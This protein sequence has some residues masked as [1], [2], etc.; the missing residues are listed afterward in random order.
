MASCGNFQTQITAIMDI[1]TES[2]ISEII[3]FLED[4][5]SALC[6][7]IS[8][9]LLGNEALKNKLHALQNG[10]GRARGHK[11][12][13]M[14][15]RSVNTRSLGVQ[16][17][18][19]EQHRE[20]VSGFKCCFNSGRNGEPAGAGDVD[21][22]LQADIIQNQSANK[23]NVR[24]EPL[25]IKQ[26]RLEE[27]LYYSDPQPSSPGE[28][29]IVPISADGKKPGTE[30][31]LFGDPEELREQHSCGHGDEELS[32]LEFVVKVEQEGE[33]VA[34]GLNLTGCGRSV[35]RLSNLGSE[36]V[37]YKRDDKLWTSFTQENSDIESDDPACCSA[38]EQ[39]SQSL[40][41]LSPIHQTPATMEDSGNTLSFV[42]A[43]CVE[44]FDKMGEKP[45]ACSEELRSE[46]IH[47]QQGQY[48]ERLEHTV[49]RENQ[50]LLPQQQQHGPSV[51]HRRGSESPAQPHS[52]SPYETGCTLRTGA[53][54][55]GKMDRK[56]VSVYRVKLTLTGVPFRF[57][58]ISTLDL[59]NLSLQQMTQLGSIV[60]MLAKATVAEIN[61]CV[62]DSCAV[63]RLEISQSQREIEQLKHQLQLLER[64]VIGRRRKKTGS[65]PA[66][67][68]N[69]IHAERMFGQECITRSRVEPTAVE[70]VEPRLQSSITM[71]QFDTES[72]PIKK[73]RL[74]E[75]LCY[76]DSQLTSTGEEQETQTA[77]VEEQ[78]D[79]EPTP[80]EELEELSEQHRCGHSDKELSGLEFV[81]K[82]EQE[83]DVAQ[84][85]SQTGCAG[86]LNNFGTECV[87]YERESELWTSFTQGNI[88]MES[89]DPVCS[90]ATE[91]CPQS[92][93][94]HSALQHA[95]TIMEVSGNALLSFG[96]SYA[97]EFD[98]M[99]EIT[100][101]CSEEFRSEAI[102]TQQG[103]YRERLVHTVEREN[104]TLLPQQQQPVP[105]I[106]HRSGSESPAQ[107][108]SGSP[109]DTG[110]TPST[111][112]VNTGKKRMALMRPGFG[113]KLFSC[114]HC[115]KS[116][117]RYS[118]LN[119]H[120]RIHT[121]MNACPAEL[122]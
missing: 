88:D 34:Q 8:R 16:G 66:M 17:F 35:G 15:E 25:F 52:G 97:E 114:T 9:N 47:T 107:P 11:A 23:G 113:G 79:N 27:D 57:R 4:S 74:E 58:L 14:R 31:T 95:P 42:G 103:Q 112:A 63:F 61:R 33:H 73:E 18:V 46:A 70:E 10:L 60:E 104:Q 81:V 121:G 99:G 53:V 56:D 85:P 93:S 32:G 55:T 118:H 19:Q 7:N 48:R 84:R 71:R 105:S 86:R 106:K 90:N 38:T 22:S 92:L 62:D 20:R 109:Y 108:H 12:A 69:F 13:G 98:K 87:M 101:I 111:S 29:V 115:G 39:C 89:K 68:E 67:L 28:Q 41:I 45:F 80:V 117:D 36:Y 110:C 75:D 59:A 83:D 122:W 94:I 65:S 26:E 64:D 2:V 51:K 24:T 72:P 100:S 40:S 91:Q 54:N 78:Q 76:S 30:S 37:M 96:A 50:T 6:V 49:E 1:I 43:S 82:A 44:E 116:F 119:L 3:K 102:H 5:S 77:P 21:A 120:Q